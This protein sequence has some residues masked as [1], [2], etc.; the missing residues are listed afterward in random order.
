[1]LMNTSQT[2]KIINEYKLS[3]KKYAEFVHNFENIV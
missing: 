1:M 2:T 3:S